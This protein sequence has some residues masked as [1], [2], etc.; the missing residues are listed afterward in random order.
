MRILPV[1]ALATLLSSSALAL[2]MG[3]MSCSFI[4]FINVLHDNP[5][6]AHRTI[7]KQRMRIIGG[8]TDEATLK[9][10]GKLRATNSRTWRPLELQNWSTWQS[11]FVGD[12]GDVLTIAHDLGANERPLNGVYKATLVSTNLTGIGATKIMLGECAIE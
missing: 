7:F 11:T 8:T 5:E 9:L 6:K 12:L 2:D 1:F 4:T 10:D 3:K